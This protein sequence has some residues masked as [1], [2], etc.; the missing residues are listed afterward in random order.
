[1]VRARQAILDAGGAEKINSFTRY[2]LALLGVISLRRSARPFRRRSCWSPIGPRSIST[3][4]R[5][6]RGRSSSPFRSCGPISRFGNCRPNWASAN[7]SAA[8]WKICRSPCRSPNNLTG[9]SWATRIDWHGFFRR[10]DL[11]LKFVD[12]W[13]LSPLRSV[14]VRRAER[15]MC[16]RFANSDGLGAIFPPIVWSVVALKCLG[17]ADDSLACQAALAELDKLMIEEDDTIRLA[18]VQESRVG[19]G[20][21]HAGPAGSGRVGRCI[22][23]S[24]KSVRWLLSREVRR[25]GDWATLKNCRRG[26]RLVFRVQQRVLSRHRTTRAWC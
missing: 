23:R 21:C 3:R 13:R 6:G 12:R 10:V 24:A 7:S 19:H 26:G 1:M 22:R 14:A 8:A 17:H 2:Y 9:M 11:A 18:A 25:R 16:E 20:P 15:W 4:C 5:P